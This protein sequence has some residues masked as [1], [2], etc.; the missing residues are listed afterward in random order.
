MDM[1]QLTT[2]MTLAKT[3]NYQKAADQLQ[4]AP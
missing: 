4:Y 1:K 3:L 2:F